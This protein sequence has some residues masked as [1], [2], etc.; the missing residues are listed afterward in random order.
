MISTD[1]TVLDLLRNRACEQ[2][3]YGKWNYADI[4]PETDTELNQVAE[5]LPEAG[6]IIEC[7]LKYYFQAGFSRLKLS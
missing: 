2:L 3:A 5:L 4:V 1:D 7:S 6:V